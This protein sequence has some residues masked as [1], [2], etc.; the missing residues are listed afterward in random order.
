VWRI[1]PESKLVVSV[2]SNPGQHTSAACANRG[3]RNIKPL[4]SGPVPTLH[5]G[6]AHTH[7]AE[8][9]KTEMKIFVDNSLVWEGPVGADARVFD[10]PAGIR[11]DNARL[12]I[13]SR[14]SGASSNQRRASVPLR[15]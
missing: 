1:A 14:G 3:Y 13:E 12:Q 2:K 6:D 9:H 7:R 15:R 8:L 4:R 11:S 10:G 5:A